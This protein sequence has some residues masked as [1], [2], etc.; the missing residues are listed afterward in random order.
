MAN[1]RS[2][3]Q[4]ICNLVSKYLDIRKTQIATNPIAPSA[5]FHCLK[6]LLDCSGNNATAAFVRNA[7]VYITVAG[8]KHAE[9]FARTLNHTE[10][11]FII[12]THRSKSKIK[13]V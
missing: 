9:R 8:T 11:Y 12:H 7:M 5:F 6:Y 13:R 4:Q 1:T 3:P 2:V 10:H